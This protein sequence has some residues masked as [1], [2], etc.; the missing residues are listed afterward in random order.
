MLRRTIVL[1]ALLLACGLCLVA[2]GPAVE[3]ALA[4]AAA[5]GAPMLGFT[6][7]HAAAQR[8]L[9]SKLDAALDGKQIEEWIRQ[10][11]S[12]PHHVG[13]PGSRANTEMI[14][15]LFREWGFETT[16]ERFDVLFPTPK[17]RVL[18]LVAPSRFVAALDEGPVPE[19]PTYGPR[20][21]VLPPYN[22][23]SIDG[24]VT[25]ELVYVNY[26][27]PADYEE[28]AKRGID[29][30]G[31]IVIARYGASWRGIKP[32]VAAEHGAI[33]CI[34]YSDPAE[35]GYAQGEPY[36]KGGWRPPQ[37]VQRGSVA[38]IPVY[39]GD[40]LTPGI[41]AVPG[42]KRLRLDEVRTFTRIP[43]LPISAR[44]A[45]PLLAALG[46]EVAPQEW[47]GA[48]PLTYRLGAG[49]AKVH[50]RVRS[51]WNTHP[52]F[53]VV[54]KLVGREL[55]DHW[56][57][58]GN[59]HDAW[60]NGATDSVS[61]ESPMLA[62]ARA[63]ALLAK[64]GWR[65]RR[66]IVYA[67]WDGEEPGLLG[68]TEHV[69]LHGDELQHKLIA[70]L[71]T[72]SNQRGVF[73]GGGSHA[74]EPLV[75]EVMRE[76]KDPLSGKT[77]ME[78][79]RAAIVVYGSPEQ[80]VEAAESGRD[81]PIEPLGSGSDFTP[82][83]QH[84]GVATLT[85][86]F[87]DEAEYGQYHSAYDTFDNYRRFGDP[88][89]LYGVALAQAGGRLTLRLAEADV[90]PFDLDRLALTIS[91]YAEEVKKLA[92][93]MREAT[94]KENRRI[95]DGIYAAAWDP[96]KKWVVPQ[97]KEPVPYLNFAPLDN[98][99]AALQEAGARHASA[100]AARQGQALSPAATAA[101]DEAILA[102]EHSLTRPQG[103]PGRPWY[104]HQVYAPG[105]YT[106]YAVKTLPAVRE[107]IEQRKWAEVDAQTVMV[108]EVL[109]AAAAAFDRAT[110]VL[111]GR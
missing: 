20:G 101:Y 44:D 61:S 76:V 87:G 1:N 28:L 80:A 46:G 111:E 26:G 15:A 9:E 88:D 54:G 94:E 4:A 45:Q 79:T 106:G 69:E 90:L 109:H 55:P 7:E 104:T 30:A 96:K 5:A 93:T 68:S 81:L 85:F 58:R 64:T 29:V 49:P 19:D 34:I 38:D 25:G 14:A 47:R 18:E 31:K 8:A 84:L 52:V 77:L 99:V 72:D 27:V 2:A 70:Y 97:P 107:A 74:L 86:G 24:D 39:A 53:N 95:R 48:L 100:L 91:G 56:V 10:L 12:R 83:L 23:Y 62:E 33:G 63:I 3:P 59:Q 43:V 32:K 71:N 17:E 92:A 78:R 67:T 65:P 50:L 75:N 11:S 42:A 36:P 89:F 13:S 57:L 108:A 103:L 82:F 105:A 21:E 35:D 102:V 51:D 98:A 66:T 22:A 40:P 16:V 41:A 60:V 73:W 110:A 6:A 37:G